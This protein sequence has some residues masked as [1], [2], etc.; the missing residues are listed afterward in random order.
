MKLSKDTKRRISTV[1]TVAKTTFHWGF[2]PV[3]LYLGFKQGA[4]P[5]TPP[6]T[7]LSLLWQWVGTFP[8]SSRL[9]IQDFWRY[10][11]QT[12]AEYWLKCL[13]V[14]AICIIDNLNSWFFA[15]EWIN[16]L[17]C[18]WLKVKDF[19]KL[20]C[21]NSDQLHDIQNILSIRLFKI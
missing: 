8:L 7:I 11:F 9:K 1:T 3:V 10:L 17:T 16:L 5:G 15:I 12:V 21:V 18:I 4:E 20:V 6:L 2:I 19:E 14:S 13:V